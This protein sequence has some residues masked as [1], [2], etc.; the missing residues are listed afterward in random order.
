MFSSVVFYVRTAEVFSMKLVV[1]AF[2]TVFTAIAQERPAMLRP[3]EQELRLSLAAMTASRHRW[4]SLPEPLPFP[5]KEAPKVI[6]RLSAEE[7]RQ[8]ADALAKLSPT[9]RMVWD[10]NIKLYVPEFRAASEIASKAQ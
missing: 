10:A 7:S 4:P 5:V 8:L 9:G 1:I 2:V 6:P 3:T